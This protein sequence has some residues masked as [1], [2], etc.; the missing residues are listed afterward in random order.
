MRNQ[1]RRIKEKSNKGFSLFTVMVAVSFVG[2]LGL[3]VL[4]IAM[5]NFQMKITD[6]K[7]KDGFYT[8]ERALE[9]VRVG[10]QQDVGEAMSTAYIK[11]LETY[12][13]DFEG[14]QTSQSESLDELR[15]AEFKELFVKEL[16]Q[17]LKSPSDPGYYD[18]K[19]LNKYLDMTKEGSAKI[20]D[21]SKE[22]L[23]VTNPEG[24]QPVMTQDLSNGVLLK[25]I[26]S[27]Y[28]D[29][30]GRAA[31]ID[32]DIRLGIP[33]VEFPTPSTLP[34]LM[35]LSIVADKG[36][37]CQGKDPVTPTVISGDVYAGIPD[38][39]D[40]NGVS[41][42]LDPGTSLQ[43]ENG[44]RF[45]CQGSINVE[46]GSK[47]LNQGVGALWA[48]GIN[49][50][51]GTVSLTGKTYLSD[52]LTVQAGNNSKITIEGAYVGYGSPDSARES[53]FK[54]NFYKDAKDTELDSSIIINGKNTTM[55]LS[56]A[57]E[58]TIAGKSYI[59]SSKIPS[60][61]EAQ[62]Q[63]DIMMGES[64]TVKGTQLAYLLPQE[65]IGD[66]TYKNPMS[67]EEYSKSQLD[68]QTDKPVA[69]WGNKTLSQIGVDEIAPVKTVYFND[70]SKS[71]TVFV[72]L[73]LN[74]TDDVK[75]S[76][77]MQM[78]YQTGKIKDN[79]DKYLSFYFGDSAGIKV[80]NSQNYL[81]YITKG[82]VLVYDGKEKKG[83]LNTASTPMENTIASQDYKNYQNIWYSLNRNMTSNVDDKKVIKN[84][85]G[86]VHH[87]VAD[88]KQTVF[89]NLVDEK[90]MKEFLKDK[91]QFYEFTMSDGSG[92]KARLMDNEN[93]EAYVINSQ[94][95]SE[96]LRLVVCTGNVKIE[97]NVKFQGI[98]VAKGTITLGSGVHLIAEPKE[99]MK[100]FQAQ[101]ADGTFSPKDI[102]WEGKDFV[103]GNSI[104]NNDGTQVSDFYD[105]AE[106]VT[107]ENW[108]KK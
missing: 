1:N 78:Y 52:D 101:T 34:D 82:N 90:R 89:S 57:E 87:Y 65:L 85:D 93:G 83:S 69:A 44:R 76:E 51:S 22:T 25:N 28:V 3:L 64:L 88:Y 45:V 32:T 24:K 84:P 39:A 104:V 21:E 86:S 77:Y 49:V 40:R 5:A 71:G 18:I 37:S 108:K 23:Y 48:K 92:L 46:N 100:V 79:M 43:I 91:N 94:T 60:G 31:I 62:N 68:I 11:V 97:D 38:R 95:N 15:Q 103:L 16:R 33:K 42:Q 17:L 58:I 106:C 9:E 99:A 8:A 105:L 7:G 75:A 2:I 19:K 14:D 54:D 30:V 55:D 29:P 59:A 35:N 50:S 107:Y 53:K 96:K 63:N 27:V 26:R 13:K 6:M 20:I 66:G 56:K 41:V 74:F 72:Y 47:F 80:N 61:N 10:L 73:Y 36:I 102:F 81:R 70:N 67:F 4:Y 98:I 12:S